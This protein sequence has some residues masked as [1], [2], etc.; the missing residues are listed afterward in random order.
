MWRLY[1]KFHTYVNIIL[2]MLIYLC[3]DNKNIA[4]F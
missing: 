2:I 4:I 1:F 3:D